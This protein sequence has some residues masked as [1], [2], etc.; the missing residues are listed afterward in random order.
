MVLRRPI[1]CTRLS[2][3][4][5]AQR[6]RINGHYGVFITYQTGGAQFAL[7]KRIDLFAPTE[8]MLLGWPKYRCKIV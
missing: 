2:G 8:Q 6:H 3:K 7:D 1:E 5:T 4:V